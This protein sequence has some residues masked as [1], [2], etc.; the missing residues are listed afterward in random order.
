MS[1]LRLWGLLAL[2]LLSP[3]LRAQEVAGLP[4]Q[5]R[6]VSEEW[7]DYTNADG[8]GLAWDVL[9]E[10][11]EPQGIKVEIRSE[12][13]VRSVGLVERGEADAWVGS[14]SQEISGA[15]YPRWNYDTDHIYAVGLASK[16]VPTLENLGSYRLA[17]VRGYK[18]QKYLPNVRDFNEIQRRDGI[19]SMLQHDRV[20]FYIDALT[21]VE[22]VL[23][24][25][26]D[27]KLFRNT[28]L[29]ELPLY[30]GFADNERGRALLAL[31]DQRMTELVKAG[32]LRRIFEHW[33][34]PYPFES[35]KFPAVT[36]QTY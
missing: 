20:D 31:Y 27:P 24:Q 34:Q 30:L 22:S 28:H 23:G 5:V 18:Y 19:L 32:G 26:E 21:E 29:V 4:A 3:L 12:P 1:G 8:S 33:K 13:Y 15:L 10:V 17:W 9:R 11:F 6:L 35:G 7:A 25:A 14:Y 16:P 2:V 36:D